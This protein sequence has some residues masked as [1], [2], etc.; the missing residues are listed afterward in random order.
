M[1]LRSAPVPLVVITPAL[2][3]S[4]GVASSRGSTTLSSCSS[5][6]MSKAGAAGLVRP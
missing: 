1:I 6:S 3:D 4:S 2:I 5:Q